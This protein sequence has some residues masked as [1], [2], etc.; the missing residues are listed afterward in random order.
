MSDKKLT[1]KQCFEIENIKL[2]EELINMKN[3]ELI[4]EYEIKNIKLEYELKIKELELKIKELELQKEKMQNN[5]E[6]KK[7]LNTIVKENNL[8]TAVVKNEIEN[9]FLEQIN[10]NNEDV[11]KELEFLESMK[12]NNTKEIISVEN[13]EGKIFL[14]KSKPLLITIN[15]SGIIF[16]KNPMLNYIDEDAYK[17]ACCHNYDK[18][19]LKEC[20][21]SFIESSVVVEYIS[22]TEIINDEMKKTKEQIEIGKKIITMVFN[23][24]IICNYTHRYCAT[25]IIKKDIFNK[26]IEELKTKLKNYTLEMEEYEKNIEEYEKINDVIYKN[27]K[28]EGI[29]LFT[30]LTEEKMNNIIKSFSNKQK[31]FSE[32]VGKLMAYSLKMFK[33]YG[34]NICSIELVINEVYPTTTYGLVSEHEEGMAYNTY[35]NFI[36]SITLPIEKLLLYLMIYFSNTLWYDTQTGKNIYLKTSLNEIKKC[37]NE[38]EE[39]KELFKLTIGKFTKTIIKKYKMDTN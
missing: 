8:N 19:T 34:D 33:Y 37:F 10:P 28:Y 2:K 7:L 3:K 4:Q 15:D 39:N 1:K 36:E 18:S 13:N 32:K 20:L 12:N 35:E 11:L 30:K 31:K 22:I 21:N 38:I 14:K 6:N 5:N 26:K 24:E 17:I 16:I 27:I 29:E 25:A 23:K 9:D